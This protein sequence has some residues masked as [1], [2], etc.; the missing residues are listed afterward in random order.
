MK[1]VKIQFLQDLKWTKAIQNS[2]PSQ[3]LF[4]LPTH[5]SLSAGL[6]SLKLRLT[7]TSSWNSLTTPTQTRY[8]SFL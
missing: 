6:T 5:S 1:A 3:V 7:I 2:E 8:F 4:L